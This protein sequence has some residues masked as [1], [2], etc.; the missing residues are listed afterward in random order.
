VRLLVICLGGAIGTGG[1]YLV[2]LAMARLGN[3]P[4]ATLAVNLVGSFLISAV[5]TWA[6]ARGAA[7]E[8]T[9]L[10][11]VTGVLGGF[12]TY[13]SFNFETLRLVQAGAPGLAALNVAL[14]V[15]GCLAAGMAGFVLAR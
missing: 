6:A 13:S 4:I 3:F 7:A 9:R 10:F 2:S 15:A 1:R 11:L 12:T 14:T 5:M 8:G